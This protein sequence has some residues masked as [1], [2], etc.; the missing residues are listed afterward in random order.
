MGFD[1]NSGK[2]IAK[3]TLIELGFQ[4]A[5][6]IGF[7]NSEIRGLRINEGVN[8]SYQLEEESNDIIEKVELLSEN[9]EKSIVVDGVM[10]CSVSKN[11]VNT[12]VNGMN[13]T[14]KEWISDGDVVVSLEFTI[15]GDAYPRE[16]VEK[17]MEVLKLGEALQVRNKTLNDLWN[18]TRVVVRSVAMTPTPAFNYQ[19]FSIALESDE[20]YLIE[21]DILK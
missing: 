15:L 2:A 5:I 1:F 12:A 11:I 6:S 8:K 17:V 19:S 7:A 4:S 14:I 16:E 3:D 18:V 9:R 13:G 10:S 21:E 20:T